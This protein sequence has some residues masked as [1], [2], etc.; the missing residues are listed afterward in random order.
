MDDPLANISVLWVVVALKS[1][2]VREH[3]CFSFISDPLRQKNKTGC[4]FCFAYIVKAH[5]AQ[6]EFRTQ[7]IFLLICG[8]AIVPNADDQ[9][10]ELMVS[11][12]LSARGDMWAPPVNAGSS[13]HVAT[14]LVFV[15]PA[16]WT[17]RRCAPPTVN[18]HKK[19][20]QWDRRSS[21]YQRPGPHAENWSSRMIWAHMETHTWHVWSRFLLCEF[22]LLMWFTVLKRMHV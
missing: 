20:S 16:P 18:S 11:R 1:C 9:T 21:N 5:R 10:S 22:W 14:S 3:L 2:S 8:T 13:L 4:L 15:L 17:A 6:G 12:K 7:S 19:K